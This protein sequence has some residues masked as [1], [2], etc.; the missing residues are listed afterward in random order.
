MARSR[1]GYTFGESV[2]HERLQGCE[3]KCEAC[4]KKTKLQ[5]HHLVG[6]YFAARNPVLT[7]FIIRSIENAQFLCQSCHQKADEDH[8]HWNERDIALLSWALFDID[9]EKVEVNQNGTYLNQVTLPKKRRGTN[10]QRRR[11]RGR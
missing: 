1:E 7:P 4:G 2:K 10:K 8:K 3:G 9:P 11:K 6:C 5:L